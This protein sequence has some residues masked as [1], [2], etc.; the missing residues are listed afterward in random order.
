M[1]NIIKQFNWHQGCDDYVSFYP[2]GTSLSHVSLHEIYFQ[3]LIR[4]S[5]R[6]SE[7]GSTG[8][9]M[10]HF[11]LQ[12]KLWHSDCALRNYFKK[13]QYLTTTTVVISCARRMVLQG[14]NHEWIRIHFFLNKRYRSVVWAWWEKVVSEL[15][16]QS[17]LLSNTVYMLQN[18]HY[19]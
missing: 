6:L 18:C 17:F 16:S 19:F 1:R 3:E 4:Y 9:Q 7:I 8:R 14:N 5:L 15:C 2:S 12:Q 13:G 10:L 11:I